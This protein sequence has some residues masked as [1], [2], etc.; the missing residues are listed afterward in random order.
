MNAQNGGQ[1]NSNNNNNKQPGLSWSTPHG[2][3]VQ[4]PAAPV[5]S[6]T[7]VPAYKAPA[8]KAVPSS[9]G[10]A[11]VIGWLAVGVVV[12]VVL[13]W[14]GT[15][16]L[17][18]NASA[19]PS[20]ASQTAS[21]TTSGTDLPAVTANS[22]A[23]MVQSPQK[24]GLSVA[25]EK[26]AVTAPTWVV[27]Y[28][29]RDGKPGNVLGAGIFTTDQTSGTVELLRGTLAG[30]T[31]FVTEQVDNG[32]RKFSLKEDPLVAIDGQTLWVTFTAN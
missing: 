13:A 10:T 26:A 31:Y 24:A 1:Q 23:L 30:Q 7:P 6:S 32:D 22:D 19:T 3:Q 17:Q 27:V 21:S 15:S 14:A 9:S 16:L 5:V 20:D 2:G 8:P 18:R 29:S 25:I 11:K 4:K 12:G 28:E